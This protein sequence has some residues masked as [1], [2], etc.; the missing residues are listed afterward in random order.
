MRKRDVILS[1]FFRLVG[2]TG[3][4]ISALSSS[5]AVFSF[6]LVKTITFEVL[7]SAVSMICCWDSIKAWQLSMKKLVLVLLVC[8]K[9]NHRE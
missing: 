4:A 3:L 1:F 9:G 8:L 5:I 6:M 2:Q 7:V